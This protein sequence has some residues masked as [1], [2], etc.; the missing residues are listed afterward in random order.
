MT[1]NSSDLLIP[2]F[3]CCAAATRMVATM[4]SQLGSAFE[5]HEAALDPRHDLAALANP[6]KAAR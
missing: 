2:P 4:L 3:S 5:H 1:L 6:K